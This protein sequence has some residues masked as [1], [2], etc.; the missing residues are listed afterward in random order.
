MIETCMG[1]ITTRNELSDL[2]GRFVGELS[3][4]HTSVLGGD[5]RSDGT[6][7]ASANLGARLMR[8][9]S[10]GGFLIEYIYKADP[11]YHHEKL[12]LDDPYLNIREGDIITNVV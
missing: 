3:A 1:S 11:D 12:P 4:L 5:I 2:I 6:N 7:I 9:E 10:K 8:D